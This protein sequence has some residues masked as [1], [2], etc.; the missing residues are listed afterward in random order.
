MDVRV[1]GNRLAQRFENGF[2]LGIGRFWRGGS[3]KTLG[4]GVHQRHWT[5]N[6]NPLQASQPCDPFVTQHGAG[7]RHLADRRPEGGQGPQ[8]ARK[9]L[10]RIG[11][12][13]HF[14][15]VAR[16]TLPAEIA[17][18]IDNLNGARTGVS[19]ITTV[20]NQVGRGLSQIGENCFERCSVPV[21][22]GQ[23]CHT[24]PG[25]LGLAASGKNCRLDW[26]AALRRALPSHDTA[27]SIA[28][29]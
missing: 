25:I 3:P 4:T 26:S 19:E 28:A 7:R 24:H 27:G 2:E 22:V 14:I 1:D 21:N 9:F 6:L 10:Q 11:P 8:L 5:L 17:N 13:Q 16:D 23:D 18:A 20:K 29:R 15:R 12:K